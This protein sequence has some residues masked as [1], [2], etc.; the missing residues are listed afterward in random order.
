MVTDVFVHSSGELGMFIVIGGCWPNGSYCLAVYWWLVTSSIVGPVEEAS[1]AGPLRLLFL[2]RLWW[3]PSMSCLWPHPLLYGWHSCWKSQVLLPNQWPMVPIGGSRS[4]STSS[5]IYK[6]AVAPK[7][8]CSGV[9]GCTSVWIL[10]GETGGLIGI[11]VEDWLDC[12]FGIEV[13]IGWGIS[14]AA[15]TGQDGCNTFFHPKNF[16]ALSSGGG[17]STWDILGMVVAARVFRLSFS[18]TLS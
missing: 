15:T 2:W 8:P 16:E 11:I 1:G 7:K 4:I 13:F 18:S 5:G 9:G 6:Q 3:C 14:P 17:S 12:T 10:D